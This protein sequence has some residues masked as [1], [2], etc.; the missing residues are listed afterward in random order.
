M[1]SFG[2]YLAMGASILLIASGCA[3]KGDGTGTDSGTDSRV[4]LSTTPSVTL[5]SNLNTVAQDGGVTLSWT[6]NNV[7]SCMA[8]GDWSGSRATSG[9][10]NRGN[11]TSDKTYI[12][13]C[14][15]AGGSVSDSVSVTVVAPSAP[16]VNITANPQSVS[17]GGSTQ[18]QWS[19]SNVDTCTA[20]GNWSGSR[21]TSGSVN[22]NNLTSEKTYILTCSGAGG[23]ASDSVTVS[24]G[25][26]PPAAPEVTLSANP[27]SV[28]SGDSTT[29][30]WS[31]TNA[32]GCTASGD[33]SGSLGT[34]GSMAR[35]NLQVD[36]TYT[37]TCSGPGGS[38]SDNVSVTVI[39]GNTNT[40]P[41]A[42][43]GVDQNATTG[44][45]VMLDGS[46]SDDADGDP[47]IFAWTFVTKPAGSA[48][49]LN[50][51]ASARPTFVA[52]VDGLYELSLVVNDGSVDSAE[53]RVSIVSSDGSFDCTLNTV[54]CVDDTSGP[55]QEFSIIQNA[56]NIS[57]PGDVV[58]VFA[59]NYAG[60]RVSSDGTAAQPIRVVAQST[61]V[62]IVSTEPFGSNAIRIEDSSYVSIEGFRI[63]GSGFSTG[64]SYDYACI[65]ARGAST[66]SPMRSLK[67]IGNQLNNC[68]PAGMYLSNVRDLQI[69]RNVI[70]NTND[71][72]GIQ[73]MGIYLA[74]AAADNAYVVENIISG[75]EG[76][77]IHMNGDSSVGGDGIQSGHQFLRNVFDGNGTNGLNMDGVQDILV[78]NNIFTNNGKH[79]IRGYRIDGSGGP[80]GWV[81]VNNT[82]YNNESAG[83]ASEDV[84][85]HIIFNNLVVDNI[86]NSFLIS[87]SNYS[88]SNNL[89]TTDQNSVFVDPSADDLRLNATS[90]AVNGGTP[91][92]MSKNAP[93]DDLSA[94][95][96]SAVPDIGAFE[97]GSSY[98]AW[99]Q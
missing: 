53:D 56:V 64:S 86:D 80:K 17:Y 84:G 19:S 92:F 49:A 75:S 68:K 3:Q 30:S 91:S 77:A 34:S 66:S 81:I 54:H 96:R 88:A 25:A 16:I 22:R 61:G 94:T 42:D 58:L 9:S 99:Y 7:D 31:S 5:T 48:A 1:L 57:Q 33:W 79:G 87:G 85:G 39:S 55:N 59:G 2:K 73:G 90:S 6:S 28:S 46:G 32:D 38:A 70:R 35:N 29:L 37:L 23:S 89:F 72:S 15:G 41:T 13:T 63:D 12:L 74:N 78:E 44:E 62:N 82:F 27:T 97:S 14:S 76:V 83:K 50:N 52:D 26:A 65:A 51:P 36:Q 60:F 8:S 69:I 98:P 43:A 4:A 67:F 11:L 47:L 20:S 24:V 40:A 93:V 95:T 45:Q 10:A 71:V 18:L 21:N